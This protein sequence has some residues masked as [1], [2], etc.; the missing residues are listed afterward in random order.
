MA[1]SPDIVTRPATEQDIA[2]WARMRL[3]LWPEY[4]LESH[5]SDAKE[6]I[7]ESGSICYLALVKGEAIGF[8]EL[9]LRPYANGCESSP[10]AFIEGVWVSST[11][12][13]QGVGRLLMEEAE[14]WTKA[15]G[16]KELGSDTDLDNSLAHDAHR[17]W[18]FQ[19][20]ERVLYFRKRL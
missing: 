3:Q 5:G 7:Q 8:L 1:K 10:V 14:R 18:G 16:L 17:G 15:R 6:F 20:T 13:Q 2:S 9:S 12:R 19:E 4:T 11:H